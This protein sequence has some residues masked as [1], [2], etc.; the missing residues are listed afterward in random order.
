MEVIMNCTWL[1]DLGNQMIH[2]VRRKSACSNFVILLLIPQSF[3]WLAA[4][5]L[6]LL[7]AILFIAVQLSAAVFLAT[8]FNYCSRG[9]P[10][11]FSP[12]VA[13]SSMF[14]TNSLCLTVCPIHEWRLFFKI[15]K[16]NFSSF[17]FWKT[18]SFVTLSVHFIFIY[19]YQMQI[20]KTEEK[21]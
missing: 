6:D 5:H 12:D 15:F 11:A 21:R 9:R 1:P 14:T 7:Q 13:P 4:F 3:D 20:K 17:N 16:S 8:C 2:F 10:T 18:S 19:V